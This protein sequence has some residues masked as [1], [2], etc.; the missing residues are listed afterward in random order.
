[1]PS[2]KNLTF[3]LP[4]VFIRPPGFMTNV[5]LEEN[6]QS[7]KKIAWPCCGLGPLPNLQESAAEGKAGQNFTNRIR[8]SGA[9][10]R[11]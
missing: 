8:N 6:A 9:G 1:M 3:P 10:V 11:T 5:Y 2:T 4:R 7:P